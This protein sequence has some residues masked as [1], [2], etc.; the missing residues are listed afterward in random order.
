MAPQIQTSLDINIKGSFTG[1]LKQVEVQDQACIEQLLQ[2]HV[3]K[4][5]R[6]KTICKATEKDCYYEDYVNAHELQSELHTAVKE[7]ASAH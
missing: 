5:N 6:V 4:L 3:I 7:G 1:W 2:D